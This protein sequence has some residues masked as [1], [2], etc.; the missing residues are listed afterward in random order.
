[1]F[2]NCAPFTKCISK[3]KNTQIE[4]ANDVDVVMSMY[5]LIKYSNIY[6]KTSQSLWQ[7]YRN[8][9]A[10]DNNNIIIDFELIK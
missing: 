1:M 2:K 10:L 4:D 7:Y 5:N 8:E 6:S 3:M 9:P